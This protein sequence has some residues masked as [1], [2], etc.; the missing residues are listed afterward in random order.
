VEDVRYQ[1][2]TEQIDTTASVGKLVLEDLSALADFER[3]LTREF[4]DAGL[5][6]SRKRGHRGGLPKQVADLRKLSL[7]RETA[8]ASVGFDSMRVC[9]FF[10]TDPSDLMDDLRA[11]TIAGGKKRPASGRHFRSETELRRFVVR[12]AHTL[13]GVR[14]LASEFSIAANGG[15]LIDAVGI[16]VTEAPVVLEFK[17]IATGLTICQ[18]LFYLDW[19]EHHRDVFTAHVGNQLGT[20]TASRIAWNAARLICIAEKIGQ[21]EEAVAR[22]VGRSV[23]LLQIRRYTGGLVTLQRPQVDG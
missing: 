6:E 2:L 17:R 15:G 22:H 19:L 21:R 3:G 9:T 5:V 23:E 11:F 13:I 12:H 7:A 18:G 4:A 1:S 10:L 20:R 14:V 8:V 16:D